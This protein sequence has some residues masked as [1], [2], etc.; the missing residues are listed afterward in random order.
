VTGTQIEEFKSELNQTESEEQRL[1]FEN[2]I[3]ED[4]DKLPTKLKQGKLIMI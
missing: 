2:K 1:P 3:K 4:L